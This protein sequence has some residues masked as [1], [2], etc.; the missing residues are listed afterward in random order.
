MDS[1]GRQLAARAYLRAAQNAKD[2]A[3]AEAYRTL[4]ESVAANQYPLS[5]GRREPGQTYQDVPSPLSI[6][7]TELAAEVADAEQWIAK[8]HAQ[9]RQWIHDDS[10]NPDEE[11]AKL[12]AVDPVVESP[13]RDRPQSRPDQQLVRTVKGVLIGLAAAALVVVVS[14]WRLFQRRKLIA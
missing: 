1:D 8:V 3:A 13:N 14:V 12:Y 9:E 7:E 11:F 2:Q 5:E 6:I 10:V 4:A